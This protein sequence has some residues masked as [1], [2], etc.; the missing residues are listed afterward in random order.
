Y[1]TGALE[2]G[3]PSADDHLVAELRPKAEARQIVPPQ[4][5]G[6]LG[7]LVL[8]A[9]VRVP[10][11]GVDLKARDLTSHPDVPV[12]ALQLPP[13]PAHDPGHREDERLPCGCGG[14]SFAEKEEGR[15]PHA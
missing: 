12:S 13:E 10:R 1:L 5:A 2:D 7:V 11:G 15:I 4:D 8:E 3:E 14:I 9:E 6:Q